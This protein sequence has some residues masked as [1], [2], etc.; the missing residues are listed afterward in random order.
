[1]VD[2]RSTGLPECGPTESSAPEPC[3]IIQQHTYDTCFVL[4]GFINTVRSFNQ[5]QLSWTNLK[6]WYIKL[7]KLGM[8]D[9]RNVL[10]HTKL[11]AQIN[12]K[13]LKNFPFEQQLFCCYFCTRNKLLLGLLAFRI[14]R[15]RYNFLLETIAI[16]MLFL[17]QKWT[18]LFTWDSS[19]CD[20]IFVPEMNYT[21]LIGIQ[22]KLTSIR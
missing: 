20:V 6:S 5:F 22:N 13:Y 11:Q 1:M 14:N 7:N 8:Q 18:K 10:H 3:F 19:Y 4:S 12:H 17:Y 16:A 21:G 15:L 9:T 2:H